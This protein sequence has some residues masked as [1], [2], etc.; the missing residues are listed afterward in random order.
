MRGVRIRSAIVAGARAAAGSGARRLADIAAA[1]RDRWALWIPAGLGAGIGA[2][3]GLPGEP[4]VWLGLSVLAVLAA[5]TSVLRSY[6]SRHRGTLVV[7]ALAAATVALGFTLAQVRT[8]LVAAPVLEKRVGPTM[9]TG[10]IVR[11]ETLPDGNRVTLEKPRIAGVGPER[12]PERVRVRLRGDPPDAWPG[13]WLR[14]RAILA[15]PPPPAASSISSAKRISRVSAALASRPAGRRSPP[16]AVARVSM[17]GCSVC[18]GCASTSPNGSAS[19]GPAPSARS[20][21]R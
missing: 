4:P 11:L 9:L 3:F 17:D 16:A 15:P 8:A 1:E 20:P 2:Y 10:R 14:V 18:R 6:A 5:A 21:R 12:T 19:T 13:D 7:V